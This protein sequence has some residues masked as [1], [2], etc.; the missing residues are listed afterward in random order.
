MNFDYL[1]SFPD[2]HQLYEYCAE[3][4][5]F[6]LTKPNISATSARKAMEYIV[7]LIYTS[8]AGDARGVTVFDMLSDSRFQHY[9]NDRTLLNTFHYIRKMGNTAVHDGG[10]YPNEAV[11]VLEN[12]HFLVG[13][14]CILLDLTKDYPQFEKPKKS[15]PAPAP[16]AEPAAPA[17]A[18]KAPANT[19]AAASAKKVT[20]EPAV[21]AKF[22]PRMRQVQFD[23]KYKR[24]E[25]ENRKRYLYACLREAG[26][27]MVSQPNQSMPGCAGLQM[28]LDDGDCVDYVLYGR[29]NRPLAIVEYTVTSQNLVAGRAKGIEQADKMAV[30]LGYKPIVYYTNGYHIYIIDQLGYPPRR[31]FQFHSMEE[32]ELLKLRVGSRRDISNPTIDDAITNRNYQKEA[33]RAACNAF[34]NHRRHSL[35]VMATGTG[36]TRISI[37]LVDVLLK[38][39]WVKNVLFLADR[40]SLVRQAHKNFT[41]LLPS[42]TTSVYSGGSLNRDA[43]ARVIFST[44]QTMIKLI[45]DDTREF[46][47]GRF[48]LIV[49]DEAHR[50]IFKKYSAL[51]HYFDALMIGLTATPRAEDNKSTY[52]M[53][54]MKNGHPD[55]AYELEAA[56]SDG[57]LVGFSVLDRTTQALRR[58]IYYDNLSEEEKEAFE[59]A[60][61]TG[62]NPELEDADFTGAVLK[63]EE[64]KKSKYINLGTI[65]AMLNDLM[66]N[67]LK[68][69]GGDKLGKTIIFARNHVE[70]E[71][72]VERFQLLYPYL[73]MDFCK[74][75]DSQIVNHLGLIDS[76][77]QRDQLPQIAVSVD[78]MDTGIDVPDV[79]NLVFFKPIKGKIKFL[80]M[81]GRGTRLS[82]DLFG[83]GLDKQGFLIFDY[84]DNFNYFRTGNTW[85]TVS[86]SS[87][88]KAWSVTPQSVLIN[89]R[90]LGILQ[91]L[92]NSS[93][94]STFDEAYKEELRQYFLSAV[95]GLCNDDVEVQYN[96]PYVSKYRTAE[97]W[98]NLTDGIVQ[99][100]TEQIL[101]LLP[102]ESDPVKV[103]TFDLMIYVIEDQVPRRA[104]QEK[105]IRRIRHG[106]GNVGKKIDAMLEELKKL[107]TIPAILQKEQLIKQ[108]HNA[109][110]LFNNFTLENCERVRKE[111][112]ELMTY[113]PDDTSY[114]VLDLKD[115]IIEG[116]NQGNLSKQTTYAERVQEYIEKGT[117]A[118]AKLR[119]LD[120]LTEQ[121]KADLHAVFTEKLGT[122]GDYAS[123]S[124]NKPLLAYLR[125]QVGI[126]E[127]AVQTKFGHFLNE[128]TLNAQQLA[129]MNQI[130]SYTRENGDIAFLDLQRVS[131]FCDVDIMGLFGEN[132][133]YIKTLVNGLHR[134]VM[135]A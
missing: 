32:L 5:E 80:Q 3:A 89:Q 19:A 88:D 101:P 95:R 43:N 120:E 107:K 40:T 34:V 47:I 71:K 135:E 84:Y 90:K 119:N 92:M 100:I 64:V 131:P 6:A 35:L 56:I 72:I 93:S 7:K 85:S 132:I 28:L 91:T 58:G 44:Y 75:I 48:D 24:N 50:S 2:M 31:V 82:A 106:F 67:G 36:K 45:N 73:G 98:D 1:K 68:I 94:L 22:G 60:F 15:A 103:K 8:L 123:L 117:P 109:D 114:Y 70:A 57:Y 59:D 102:P 129:Y 66:K 115:Y 52:E 124:G 69:E 21:V 53:F 14:F 108:M 62:D 54:E 27:A 105:D 55:Y 16:K 111:L 33:I 42:L 116:G 113:I 77:E 9:I 20:V 104:A 61:A 99:E 23:V 130:I 127:E 12:L 83:P 121:E 133:Q 112:R 37:A 86:E 38:A 128:D 118:L 96:M 122:P 29:D 63:A 110:L 79:L 13:E 49:V 30:K 25:A 97:Q 51:F 10:L 17:A 74:V 46:S 26:W 78:M 76:F 126:A 41:K 125:V 134:P 65:D 11:E 81:I 4:E 87:N 39:G 18:E